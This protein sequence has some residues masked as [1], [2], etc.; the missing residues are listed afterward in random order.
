MFNLLEFVSG[1]RIF[2]QFKVNDLL[3]LEYK[4][5]ADQAAV[6]VGQNIIIFCLSCEARKCGRA[7]VHNTVSGKGRRSL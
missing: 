4:C 2:K 7:L 3:F 6:K 1:N 5:V